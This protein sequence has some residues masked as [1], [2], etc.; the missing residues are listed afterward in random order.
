MGSGA[1][2]GLGGVQAQESLGWTLLRPSPQGLA[3]A[4][5]ELQGPSLLWRALTK[6]TLISWFMRSC[7]VSLGEKDQQE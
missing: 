7:Q 6:A 4:L 3:K 2:R 5:P 1:G